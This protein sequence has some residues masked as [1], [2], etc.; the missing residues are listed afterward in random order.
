MDDTEPLEAGIAEVPSSQEAATDSVC[1]DDPCKTAEK[2]K[3]PSKENEEPCESPQT[4]E[5]TVVGFQ[6]QNP[7]P[8]EQPQYESIP[9]PASR[10]QYIPLVQL[11]QPPPSRP[12]QRPPPPTKVKKA[13]K[14]RKGGKGCYQQLAENLAVELASMNE[15][16]HQKLRVSSDILQTKELGDV[17][18]FGEV[19]E[20]YVFVN[21]QGDNQK[22]FVNIHLSLSVTFK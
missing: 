16:L 20:S 6:V 2:E 7:L 1:N 9:D 5:E 21:Q 4:T 17:Q 12:P 15:K 19:E 11:M 10:E 13:T 18:H 3:L 8:A 14:G 22:R